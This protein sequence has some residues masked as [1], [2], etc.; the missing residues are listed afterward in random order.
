MAGHK[1]RDK[2]IEFRQGFHSIIPP[3]PNE[4]IVG[5][6]QQL[7]RLLENLE[8]FVL[9][10]VHGGN[11]PHLNTPPTH[12]GCRFARHS[13][14]HRTRSA[15]ESCFFRSVFSAAQ[16]SVGRDVGSVIF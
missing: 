12:S 2:C 4:V 7:S 8:Q 1:A 5:K 15:T 14:S 10:T 9:G 6:H 16:S 11:F 3:R 13:D